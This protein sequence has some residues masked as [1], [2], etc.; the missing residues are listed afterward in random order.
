MQKDALTNKPTQALLPPH[1]PQSS[2]TLPLLHGGGR[3][4]VEGIKCVG[5][6]GGGGGET[7]WARRRSRRK[8]ARRI[9]RCKCRPIRL[10]ILY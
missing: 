7:C 6:R 1:T 10:R 5:S 3:G 9:L 4:G 2:I 8:R